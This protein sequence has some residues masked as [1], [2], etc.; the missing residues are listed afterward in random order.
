MLG[1][2]SPFFWATIKQRTRQLLSHHSWKGTD[3]IA[4]IFGEN[5]FVAHSA[6]SAPSVDL[7][8]SPAISQVVASDRA[9]THGPVFPEVAQVR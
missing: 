6:R 8:F 1:Q 9:Q 2:S 7:D 3:D 4:A 5:L